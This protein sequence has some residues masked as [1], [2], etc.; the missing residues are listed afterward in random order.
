[1]SDLPPL[2]SAVEAI[3]TVD[4]SRGF[5]TQ[6]EGLEVVITAA[7]CLPHLPPAYSACG[8][9]EKT[10]FNLLGPVGEDN[11]SIAAECLFVNPVADIAILGA[12]DN[13]MFIDQSEAY[14]SLMEGKQLDIV[15]APEEGKAWLLDLNMEWGPCAFERVANNL[16]LT[17][18]T[19][20]ILGGMSGSPIMMENGG[21]IGVVVVGSIIGPGDADSDMDACFDGGPNPTLMADLP[22]WFFNNQ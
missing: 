1:M 13:Q 4:K 6:C 2:G 16:W 7:H 12:P 5:V 21:A 11:P 20:G 19:Q 17:N 22:G 10:Y 18:A 15:D 3:V 8:T 14:W 9:Q